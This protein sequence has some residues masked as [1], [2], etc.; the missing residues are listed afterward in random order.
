MEVVLYSTS[1]PKCKVLKKKLENKKIK[2]SENENV[3]K[4]LELGFTKVPVLEVEG[5][6]LNFFDAN[7]WVN[8]F[9]IN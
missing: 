3:K 1:C 5:K 6:Y 4:L 9:D 7:N 8:N 2:F